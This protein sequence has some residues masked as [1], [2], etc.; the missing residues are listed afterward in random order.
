[1]V[2]ANG[3][4]LGVFDLGEDEWDRPVLDIRQAELPDRFAE[5]TAVLG[6]RQITG[7]ARR[8]QLRHLRRALSAQI[9]EGALDQTV[10]DVQAIADELRPEII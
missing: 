7:V 10:R 2:L 4:R 5:L 6:A 8:R 1:M 9:D 3:I